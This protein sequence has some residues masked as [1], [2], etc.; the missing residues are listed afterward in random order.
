MVA[1]PIPWKLAFWLCA[2]AVLVLSLGPV[3]PQLPTTGWDKSNHL[4]AFC[5]LTTLG[6]QAYPARPLQ[7][8]IGLM[9]YGGAIELLQM[10]TPDRYAEWLDWLADVLG[11]AFGH[12]LASCLCQWIPSR[13]NRD[14]PF[15]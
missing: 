9:L 12:V 2:L 7:I 5:V 4:L 11:I 14:R 15:Q 6:R 1:Q 3:S 13:Q 10:L 8:I